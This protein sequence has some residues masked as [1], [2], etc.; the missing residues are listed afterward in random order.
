[1]L[2]LYRESHYAH[3]PRRYMLCAGSAR[4]GVRRSQH[5]SK[6]STG[7]IG[8]QVALPRKIAVRYLSGW[9]WVNAKL[10]LNFSSSETV[11][12]SPKSSDVSPCSQATTGGHRA[13]MGTPKFQT[14]AFPATLFMSF[15]CPCKKH[16]HRLLQKVLEPRISCVPEEARC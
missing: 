13:R 9:F 7:A 14:N 11:G 5:T 3:A 12:Q 16:I 6:A 10:G 15:G 4:I 2:D 1:M 8:C